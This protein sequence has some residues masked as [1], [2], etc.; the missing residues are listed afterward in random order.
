MKENKVKDKLKCFEAF[1][2][3]LELLKLDTMM[4]RT[5]VLYVALLL[6]QFVTFLEIVVKYTDSQVAI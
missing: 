3:E 5:L 4:S 2:N 1:D 6:L